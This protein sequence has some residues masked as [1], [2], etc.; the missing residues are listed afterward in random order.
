MSSANLNIM[1][2]FVALMTLCTV[3]LISCGDEKTKIEEQ[4]KYSVV[5]IHSWDSIGEEKDLFT[6]TMKEAFD[7]EG[8]NVEIHHIYA[9]M[10]HR[11][12]RVFDET[13]WPVVKDSINSF[14]PDVI[15][16]NDDPILDWVFTYDS[17]DSL[18]RSTPSVFAG[19]NCLMRDSLYKFPLMTGYED[20][21]NYERNL[22][23]ASSM[24][25][26][27]DPTIELS[28][29]HYDNR[30]RKQIYSVLEDSSRYVNNGDFH[31][32]RF[33]SAYLAEN[34]PGKIMVNFISASTPYTNHA[35]NQ[36]D[37]VGNLITM[38]VYQFARE[39][40]QLQVK[41]DIYSNNI[42]DRTR[43]PQFT[44]IREQFNNPNNIRFLCGYFTSTETQ[45]VDQVSCAARILRGEN[46]RAIPISIHLSDYYM[47]W[48]A[49]Q[50]MNPQLSYGDY[51]DKFKII[52]APYHQEHPILLGVHIMINLVIVS[53][54]IY[55]IVFLVSRWK[56]KGEIDMMDNLMYEE[57]VHD[58]LFLNSMDTIWSMK[59]GII[60]Y[61]K[62]FAE[63][64][65]NGK[66]YLTEDEFAEMV[67]PES[68][69][70]LMLIRDFR[71]QRGKQSI[72]MKVTTDKGKTWHWVEA[73]Y[74]VTDKSA[75]QG[76]IHGLL[77][78]VDS[79]KETEDKL[80]KAQELASQVSLKENFLANI[81][82]DLRT[83]LGAVTGFSSLLTMPGMQFEE[84]EREQY[85]QIIHENTDMILGMIDTVMHKA[86]IET[87][88]MEII[89][90][91][92]SV[93]ALIESCYKT[94]RIIAPTNL[95]FNL[96]E[97]DGDAMINIDV[98]R[99]KQVVNN[100]LSNAFKFTLK[101]S[102]T[103]GWKMLPDGKTVEVYVSDSGIGIPEDKCKDVFSRYVKVTENDKGTGLGLNI[104]KAIVEKQNGTIGV[105]S[106]YGKGS[107]FF[108][109]LA[110]YVECLLL[111]A[112]VCFGAIFT[113]CD[114]NKF[115]RDPAKKANVL[116]LHGYDED[117]GAYK[118]FNETISQTLRHNGINPN[119]RNLFFE[120]ENPGYD[121]SALL[122]AKK[123]SVLRDGWMPDIILS[124]GDRTARI[125]FDYIYENGVV[126]IQGVPVVLGGL[127]HP[128]WDEIR[129]HK[130]IVAIYDPIDY[131]TNIN[132]AVEMSGVN[133]VE[134]ELDYFHQDSLIRKELRE[135]IA[136]PPYLDNSDFHLDT[137]RHERFST[138]WK[139]SIVVL[140]YSCARPEMNTRNPGEDT[141]GL[142]IAGLRNIYTHAWQYPSLAL[143]MDIFSSDIVDKTGA[144]QFTAVKAGF[145]DGK[146][147]YL[148]GYFSGYETV[149]TDLGEIGSMII[150][151]KKS[152]GEMSGLTHKKQFYMD[153]QAMQAL[154]LKYSDYCD[155]F[156]IVGAP[157][158]CTMPVVYYGTWGVIIVFVISG[159]FLIMLL[160]QTWREK[161][162]QKLY[163]NVR[164]RAEIRELA[165]HGADSRAV[166]T[167]DNVKDI[168]SHI[169]P[170]HSSEIPLMLQSIDIA[171]AHSYEICADIEGDGNYRWWQLRFVV[172]NLGTE[173]K[174]V[175][176]ILINI[177]EAKR[178]E[179]DL[180]HAMVL[181]EEA[182]QKEDFLTT[183]SH[184]IRTP[185]N[186]V[187]GFSDVI[188]SL[189]EEYFTPQELADYGKYIKK[190]NASLTSMIEDILM[191]SRIESGRLKYIE[192]DFCIYDLLQEI[193]NEWKDL[194]P[195]N[196]NFITAGFRHRPHVKNDKVRLR[197]ILNQLLHNAT[198]FTK[199]GSIILSSIYHF[200]EDE[201]EIII[202]DTG[203]G[204]PKDK[205]EAVFGLFWKDNEFVPGL[206][207]GLHIVRKLAEGMRIRIV[208]DSKEGYGSRF[209]VFIPAYLHDATVEK[210]SI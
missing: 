169:H 180:R 209:S 110:K 195:D 96:E 108:F 16:L 12:A 139:D 202:G 137:I 196:V 41:Y 133:C 80:R 104:S 121:N 167:E 65:L 101:G 34:F 189:P 203:I 84:G 136:R 38:R 95:M 54:V 109:R 144:P 42:I 37:S 192:E 149:A 159:I 14:K 20:R 162:S 166:R 125:F 94:N 33:D 64:V 106:T 131:I 187:V 66:E 141:E 143:K 157:M 28:Y 199:Q 128:N 63:S 193:S 168:I 135:A 25:N 8:L 23:L 9:N 164:N 155:R 99:T 173:N 22:S 154:D 126:D 190:N 62:A 181:A 79:K 129:Q 57:K 114:S 49:M 171:G 113:S 89:C 35:E 68:I 91:P 120:Q 40:A 179:E 107:K 2:L 182:K 210:M 200:N 47:D 119:I 11:P 197:Y 176:G 103:L 130:N 183:I 172:Q 31:I 178:Y 18:L 118:S 92:V 188:I 77:L 50:L 148:C 102:V 87:G 73:T 111:I 10:I 146:G 142:G 204:I 72:R 198:K 51:S 67:H 55:M 165:I 140:T 132:L 185:L 201:V 174:R 52:N 83:P 150:N 161:S 13:D 90:K 1:K 19:V 97:P 86:A 208:V 85:G 69:P 156:I 70:S 186:A 153:Y 105:E 116:I 59:D 36:T 6:N 147:R 124:E 15:L 53:L 100:F 78:N 205:Q 56:R 26:Q 44:C 206:G 60:R 117:Y 158:E 71:N 98:T 82:H 175:D 45:V 138:D 58:L 48:N 76:E 5:V 74:T 43:T 17:A 191:F 3:L 177:D 207:L 127:H 75:K 134:V 151:G 32:Q 122:Y 46:P 152:P 163:E 21:I 24:A 30:I 88:E 112:T 145:A 194:M 160:L 81:S 93:K 29:S 115:S 39:R 184:E 170:E 7:N 4:Q 61:N 27:Q 123:D